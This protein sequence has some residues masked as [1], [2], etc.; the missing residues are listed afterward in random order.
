M[1]DFGGKS[2]L[3]V[4][5]VRNHFLSSYDPTLDKDTFVFF[6][7]KIVEFNIFLIFFFKSYKK[8]VNINGKNVSLTVLDV[9]GLEENAP[10]R[11]N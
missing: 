4:R 6:F 5:V 1:L 8:S 7:L 10:Y 2:A 3:T 11:Y 9:A